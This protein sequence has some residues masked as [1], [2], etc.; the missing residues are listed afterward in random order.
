MQQT[1]IFSLI[2]LRMQ[3]RRTQSKN[4]ILAH[5]PGDHQMARE[6]GRPFTDHVAHRIVVT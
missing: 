2:L 4:I 6:L 5:C 1:D 3:A